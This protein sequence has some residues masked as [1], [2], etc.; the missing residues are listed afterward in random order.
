VDAPVVAAVVSSVSAIVVAGAS[1]GFAYW[2]KV[3]ADNRLDALEKQQREDD[4]W[5]IYTFDA[6]KRLYTE[7]GPLLFAL[8]EACDELQ[9]RIRGISRR[10]ADGLLE[11]NA[12]NRF[13][14]GSDYLLSTLYRLMA[15]VAIARLVQDR[16]TLVDLAVDPAVDRIYSLAKLMRRTW[17]A[18]SDLAERRGLPYQPVRNGRTP[19]TAKQHVNLRAVDRLA[20]QLVPP[21]QREG[22]GALLPYS[23]FL[24]IHSDDAGDRSAAEP[25]E[26]LFDRFHP[27]RRPVLWQLLCTEALLAASIVR[28]AARGGEGWGTSGDPLADLPQKM[29]NRS[30]PADQ[31]EDVAPAVSAV[32][33]DYAL[34]RLPASLFDGA[35]AG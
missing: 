31:E 2:S 28:N 32:A 7:L 13:A 35:Q 9:W 34:S 18:G 17:N 3:R 10:A 21:A 29:V 20:E 14:P 12:D 1:A 8:V 6:R 33:R 24:T 5:R 23:S 26:R 11:E 16:L 15:P 25:F 19:E 4:A 30:G 22:A 27:D